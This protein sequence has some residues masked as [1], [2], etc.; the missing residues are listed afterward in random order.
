MGSVSA[1][2]RGR[3]QNWHQ[4]KH[5]YKEHGNGHA[6]GHDKHGRDNYIVDYRHDDRYEHDNRYRHYSHAHGD[7][8]YAPRRHGRQDWAIA[9][10]YNYR[11]HVYFPDY[12][13]FYDARRRGYVYRNRGQWLFSVAV[14]SIIAGVDLDNARIEYMNNVP[15]DAYPQSY[16]DYYNNPPSGVRLNLQVRL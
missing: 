1:Q 11:R 6:Y 7:D 5:E 4:D 16:Y 10:G 13:V 14:P 9:H 15:L 3:G 2:G 8:Y 12:H